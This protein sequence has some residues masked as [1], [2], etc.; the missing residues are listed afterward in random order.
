M[1]TEEENGLNVLKEGNYEKSKEIFSRIIEQKPESVTSRLGLSFSLL[2]LGDIP[3]AEKHLKVA[4]SLCEA[5]DKLPEAY[6]SAKKL[7][8]LKPER[9]DYTFNL[10]KIYLKLNFMKSFVELLLET[11]DKPDVREEEFKENVTLIIPFI[12]DENIKF[13]LSSKKNVKTREEGKLNPFENL[14]LANLLFEIGS[15]EEAKTEYYKTAREFLNKDLKEKA[16]ELYVKIKELYPDD[17]E[18]EPLKKEIDSYTKENN[19]VELKDREAKLKEVLPTLKDENEARVRYAFAVTFKGYARFAEAK[20]ELNKVF[21]LPKT[22]EKI[23]AYVLLSQI[24]IDVQDN[25]KAIETL[26]NVIVEGEFAGVDLVPLEYKLATIYERNGKLPE[27]LQIYEKALDEDPDYLDLVEKI[28][29]VR[30]LIE[31]SKVAV[32]GEAK[33]AMVVSEEVKEAEQKEKALEEEIGKEVDEKKALRN[34]ILYI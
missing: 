11:M 32:K 31:K 17:S 4:F 29:K 12:E 6:I 24:Y 22:A 30:K 13:L 26:E 25:A 9:I 16:Q 33:E 19:I 8:D 10:L 23:K 15:A 3:N 7:L 18:L 27:A 28:R 21:N 14:E 34:R 5:Q 20:K 2:E 1:K